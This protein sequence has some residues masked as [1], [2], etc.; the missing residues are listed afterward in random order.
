MRPEMMCLFAGMIMIM[1]LSG[2]VLQAVEPPIIAPPDKTTGLAT[3]NLARVTGSAIVERQELQMTGINLDNE[4]FHEEFSFIIFP[5]VSTIELEE[6]SKY[7]VYFEVDSPIQFVVYS[8]KRY[9][10]WRQSGTHTISKATTKSG[11]DCC[12]TSSSFSIEIN[13]GEEGRYYLVFD[14]SGL[15][16]AGKKPSIGILGVAKTGNI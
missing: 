12:A 2:C 16:L 3:P 13:N 7:S 14:D 1:L 4:V 6:G 10:E 9:N 11:P 8:E 5:R 15:K